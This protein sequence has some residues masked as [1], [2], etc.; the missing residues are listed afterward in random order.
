MAKKINLT[1][2]QIEAAAKAG[3]EKTEKAYAQK[4]QAIAKGYGTNSAKSKV[5]KNRGQL[6]GV[7]E[8]LARNNPAF[9][10]LQQ[11]GSAKKLTK[12][13]DA[14][15]Y[16]KKSSERKPGQISALGAGDYGA[17][18]TTRFDATANAAIYL[19]LIQI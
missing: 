3:R 16:G 14:I 11:A 5:G 7:S 15:S 8:V 2:E 6:P 18:K 4:A 12:G 1:K 9:A 10:A 17:S 13:S 19:S